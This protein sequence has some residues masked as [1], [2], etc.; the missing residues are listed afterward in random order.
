MLGDLWPTKPQPAPQRY[1]RFRPQVHNVLSA[2][3]EHGYS[4]LF[5][6]VFLEAIGIPV[7]AALALLAAGGAS[8][9][10]PLQARVAIPTAL[11]A[12][13]LGDT[14]MFL[15]GRYT[16]WFFLSLLCRISLNP[17]ACVLKSAESFYR[18][19]RVTLLIAKFIPGINTMAPPLA[20]S[21][22]MRLLQFLSL[23]AVGASLYVGFYFGLGFL[24]SD[25]IGAITGKVEAFGRVAEYAFGLAVV[26]YLFLQIRMRWRARV[27][28]TVPRV[29]VGEVARALGSEEGAVIFDVRS[30]G[31]YDQDAMRIQGSVRLEPNALM[32]QLDTLPKDKPIYVYCTCVR[33]ATSARVAHHLRENGLQSA[34]ITGGLR[35]WKKADL[36]MEPVPT[37][38]NSAPA[39]VFLTFGARRSAAPTSPFLSA[40]SHL[41]VDIQRRDGHGAPMDLWPPK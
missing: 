30:H 13:L 31:Y 7:P 18:R 14:L 41:R 37:D 21:M 2:I 6:I 33:E 40:D 19:G 10:G 9:R 8:A 4:I 22:N 39:Q 34:V 29:D 36:P 26:V 27:F 3:A 25:L 35:S 1:Y 32:H 23:D 17:E 38:E 11:S 28:N 12:M 24:F 5:A 15:L 16:G 20:G